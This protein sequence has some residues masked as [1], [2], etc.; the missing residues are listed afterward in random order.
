VFQAAGHIS[1]A[2]EATLQMAE[3][4][5]IPRD[6]ITNIECQNVHI[7]TAL[8]VPDNGQGVETLL[9]LRRR[10]LNNHT[11]HESMFEF[12]ITSVTSTKDDDTF[13]EHAHGLVSYDSQTHGTAYYYLL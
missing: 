4:K 3:Y 1:M 11:Y 5:G 10:R 12:T 9:S 2:F 13:I 6:S 7:T 8:V